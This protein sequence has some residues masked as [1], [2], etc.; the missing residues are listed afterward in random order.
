MKKKYFKFGYT[1]IELLLTIGIIL[2]LIVGVFFIYNKATMSQK[3][4]TVSDDIKYSI[5][6]YKRIIDV[7]PISSFGVSGG[8]CEMLVVIS[9][10]LPMV[11]EQPA[12]D[13]NMARGSASKTYKGPDGNKVVISSS[14]NKNTN[15]SELR[16][17]ILGSIDKEFCVRVVMNN[18]NNISHVLVGEQNSAEGGQVGNV[19][20]KKVDVNSLAEQCESV[21]K[22]GK[23]GGLYFTIYSDK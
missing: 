19:W 17:D 18:I 1:L 21:Q 10:N 20:T 22:M 23:Y 2:I 7:H 11:S 6:E 3:I 15:K 5:S 12:F 16:Y 4:N 14:G 8:C 13:E 9:S